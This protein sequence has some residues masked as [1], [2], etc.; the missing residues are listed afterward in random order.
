MMGTECSVVQKKNY[1][2]ILTAILSSTFLIEQ[3]SAQV[4][5]ANQLQLHFGSGYRFG[6]NGA[7]TT[8]R[9]MVELQ[10]LSIYEHGDLFYFV[11]IY[12]DH[13]WDG[14]SSRMGLYGELYGHVSAKSFG[15]PLDDGAFLADVAPGFGINA[16]ADFLVGMYGIRT[17][18][19]VPGF[20]F[21]SLG[22]YAY[23]NQIDPRGRDLDTT[24]LAKLLWDV[25]FSIGDQK[26][27][28][29]GSLNWIGPQGAG[30]ERQISFQPEIRWDVAN[31]LGAK[32]NSYD[33][34]LR[35][36]YFNNTYGVKDVDQNALSFFVA[37]KF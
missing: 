12:G 34:G 36:V 23:D 21:L 35:Y 13:K 7:E 15:M 17:S 9:T 33:V 6:G 24:Y 32:E 8:A 4:F 27:S 10:H 26:F 5:S 30:A 29:G 22:L 3:A 31:A 14:L 37:K 11:D 28:T 1:F 19:K 20:K 18:F 2:I 25:P 16:G